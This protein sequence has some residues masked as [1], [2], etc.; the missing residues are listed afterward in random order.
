MGKTPRIAIQIEKNRAH[1]RALLLGIA[2][3]ALERTDWRLEEAD[4]ARLTDR[5]YL[6]R[7]DGLIVRVM[8]NRTAEA[9]VESKKPVVDVYGRMDDN[10]LPSI[11]LDDCALARMAAQCF[12]DHR[13]EDVAYCGLG[14][15]RFSAA[16][17]AAFAASAA[18]NGWHLD[19]C[20]ESPK[21]RLSDTFF[22]NERTDRIPDAPLLKKWLESMPKP[23]AIFCCNDLRAIQVLKTCSAAGIAVPQDV[24]VLGV[25]NDTVLCTFTSPPLSSIETDP[26]ALGRQAAQLLAE[27]LDTPRRQRAPATL[28][29][30]PR[31]VIERT[32][33]ATYSFRTPW[34]SDAFIFIRQRLGDGITAADVVRHLGY[35]H[36]YVN[37]LFKAEVGRSL[38]QEIIRQRLE[39]ACRLLRTTTRTAA[40]IAAE[41]GYP[42]AQYFSHIFAAAFRTTPAAWRQ[43]KTK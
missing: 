23:V 9:L 13:F 28:L 16:R 30:A 7:F 29:H 6:A 11:R 14:G 2:N 26:A 19:T 15:L 34:L 12:A 42:S 24:A 8:D 31:C 10:P 27:L 39:R 33:T 5:D 37:R 25:D 21:A 18:E 32:S 41:C 38:Q 36:V 3:Y 20:P 22:R 1:G 35:S 4:P 40:T 17:G 43:L